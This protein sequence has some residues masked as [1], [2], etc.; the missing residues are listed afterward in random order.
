[1]T[2]LG[3]TASALLAAGNG[4]CNYDVAGSL[5]R[6]VR[7]Y[8]RR[9]PQQTSDA[10]D[11]RYSALE[12]ILRQADTEHEILQE[13]CSSAAFTPIDGQL[14][15]VSAWA[16]ALQSD[17]SIAHF[18]LLH[19]AAAATTSSHAL[20]ADAWY[21][22]ATTVQNER[23]GTATEPPIIAVVIPKVRVRAAAQGLALP[24]FAEATQYWR[25]TKDSG[26]APCPNASP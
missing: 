10:L 21:A 4:R 23:G 2:L 17:V 25:D 5:E 16:Y 19:C 3:I 9:A 1:M 6:Q 8:D 24:A 13:E 18:T 26:V 7:A 15:G 14:A 11:G 20:L 22:L 12:S